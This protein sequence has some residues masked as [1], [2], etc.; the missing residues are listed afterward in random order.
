MTSVGGV[1]GTGIGSKETTPEPG[2]K[3]ARRAS[4]LDRR[5]TERI[6]H[7]IDDYFVPQ[8]ALYGPPRPHGRER[9]EDDRCEI[10]GQRCERVMCRLCDE[11]L[12]GW[13]RRRAETVFDP[14]WET[15]E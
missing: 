2:E 1:K 14:R 15:D 3:R 6:L 10:C 7:A 5:T 8:E 12:E 13:A 4:W 11:Q 9:T